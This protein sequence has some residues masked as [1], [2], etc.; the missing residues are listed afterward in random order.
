MRYWLLWP[1]LGLLVACTKH[2]QFRT[3]SPEVV[4]IDEL[5]Q[6]FKLPAAI[7]DLAQ[8][9]GNKGTKEEAPKK[10]GA[11]EETA[12]ANVIYTGVKVY[13]TEKNDRILRTPSYRLELPSGGGEVDLANYVT[14]SAGSFFV[15]FDLPAEFQEGKNFHV[16]YVS[17]ARKRRID[18]RVFG[19]GCTQYFD[20]TKKFIEMMK[21]EGLKVNTTRERDV[22]VLAGHYIFSVM[23]DDQIYI[24]QVTITDSQHKNLLCEGT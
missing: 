7:W 19:G 18:D 14:G 20:I 17:T 22:T 11:A 16:F 8:Q 3:E 10:E 4:K 13:L 15:G 23:K 5:P 12:Q 24:S 1:C 21:N 2:F 6:D 9:G